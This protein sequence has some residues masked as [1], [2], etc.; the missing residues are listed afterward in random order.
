MLDALDAMLHQ[1]LAA[2][3]TLLRA[4]TPPTVLDDQIGFR[5]P[6]VDWRSDVDGLSPRRALN[7]YLADLRENRKLRSNERIRSVAGGVITEEPAPVWVDCHY[8]ITAWSPALET[9]GRTHDEH[10]LLGEVLAVLTTAQPLVP[11]RVFAPA[12]LPAGFPDHLADIELPLAVVPTEGFARLPEFW[13]SM[14]G[15]FH[16]WK[17]AVV[18]VISAPVKQVA[19]IS[20]PP[21]TT[22]TAGIRTNG[23]ADTLVAI[24]GTLVDKTG[25]SPRVVSGATVGIE[26]AAGERVASTQ[27]DSSG[28]FRFGCFGPGQYRLR[29]TAAGF[30]PTSRDVDVPSTSGEYDLELS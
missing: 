1:L 20:G 19:L 21:V 23:S 7:V 27:S 12:A 28:H 18:T 30:A 2:R 6:D 5:A 11:R 16:P 4:G 13:T 24:G 25:A 29:A 3:M 22:A 14:S 10:E 9:A 8:L 26:T 15:P 17:P